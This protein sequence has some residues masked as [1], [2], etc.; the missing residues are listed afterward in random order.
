[1]TKA[2]TALIVLA[3]LAPTHAQTPINKLAEQVGLNACASAI[4]TVQDDIFKSRPYRTHQVV[5]T[6]SPKNHAYSTISIMDYK[7]DDSHITLTASPTPNGKCDVVYVETYSWYENC[8]ATR[9]DGFRKYNQIGKMNETIVLQYMR[10]ERLMAY[11]TPQNHT[12]TCLVTK[13]KVY[14]AQ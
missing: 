14:Y 9:L 2:L 12:G 6:L 8:I 13:R 10:D 1:M 3:L 4:K 5:N 7:G 11:L